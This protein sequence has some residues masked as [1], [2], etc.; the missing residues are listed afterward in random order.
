MKKETKEEFR[1]LIEER[2]KNRERVGFLILLR[3]KSY[4]LYL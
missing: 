2:I 1:Q 3:P 4:F